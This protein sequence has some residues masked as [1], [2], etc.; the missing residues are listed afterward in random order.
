MLYASPVLSANEDID[1]FVPH[2]PIFQPMTFIPSSSKFNYDIFLS[3][4][5]TV[6]RPIRL[7]IFS[8]EAQGL[9]GG[10]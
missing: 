7:K 5:R 8:Y 3:T 9:S 6:K 10:S 4:I 1:G 2:A